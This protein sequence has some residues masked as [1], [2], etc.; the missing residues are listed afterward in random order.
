MFIT[1]Y[2]KSTAQILIRWSLQRGFVC[3]PKSVKKERI[4]ENGNVFDF[5]IS[6]ED[7]AEMVIIS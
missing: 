7:M 4:I 3:I 6:S 5:E 2:G 1:R